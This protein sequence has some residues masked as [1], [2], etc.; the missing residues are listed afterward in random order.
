MDRERVEDLVRDDEAVSTVV[1]ASA[2]DTDG[3]LPEVAVDRLHGRDGLTAGV[4]AAL[5]A[6][7]VRTARRAALR[8]GLE[9]DGRRLLVRV[10]GALLTL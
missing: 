3:V 8:A 2:E 7:T 6:H 4:V 1:A 9:D 5:R 10:T